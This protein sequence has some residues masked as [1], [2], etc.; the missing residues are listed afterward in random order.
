MRTDA[1]PIR[2][3]AVDDH[4]LLLEGIA[5]LINAVAVELADHG[6]EAT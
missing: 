3:L 6:A 4:A 2:V 1:G 5:A